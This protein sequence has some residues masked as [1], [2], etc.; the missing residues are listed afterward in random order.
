MQL[1]KYENMKNKL[2]FLLILF[3]LSVFA[4]MAKPYVD[5]TQHSVIFG[6][7]D[8]SVQ[9]ENIHIT[10]KQMDDS[11][12]TSYK[13]KYII[14]SDKKQT[15]PLLFIGIGLQECHKVLINGKTADI[16]LL[17]DSNY[18]FLR[19]EYGN[20]VVKYSKDSE[21]HV[22]KSDLIYFIAGLDEGEN[23]ICIEYDAF[24]EYNVF[25]F[26]RNY[27]LEY[28]LFPSK[29]WKSFGPINLEIELIDDLTIKKSNIGKPVIENKANTNSNVA[30]WTLKSTDSDISLVLSKKIS[31]FS[32]VLLWLQP[33]GIATIVFLLLF[34][35]HIRLLKR[36]KKM[37]AIFWIGIVL[38]PILFYVTFFAS[39]N[40]IDFSLGQE[41]SRHGYVFLLVVTYPILAI[42]Y[43]LIMWFI[44]KK[45]K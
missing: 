44:K 33:F 29:Y 45:I 3:P 43:G 12:Y 16:Q 26:V 18:S 35:L 23:I 28:S 27:K 10:L 40:L 6:A 39:F 15:L 1:H 25:G 19:K 30:K 17:N 38:I 13:I 22:G 14:E 2:L 4:N 36:Q 31:P 24:L 9:S 8:C 42:V 11:Y 34:I 32:E 5:G 20:Y 7:N 37:K 21:I 41:T